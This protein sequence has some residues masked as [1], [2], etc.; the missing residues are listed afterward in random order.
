[1]VGRVP[2]EH[3]GRVI[4]LGAFLLA[5]VEDWIYPDTV[6]TEHGETGR[7]VLR[8]LGFFDVTAVVRAQ[9]IDIINRAAHHGEIG[10]AVDA[11]ARA[12]QTYQRTTR[13][14]GGTGGEADHQ[15][16]TGALIEARACYTRLRIRARAD[17]VLRTAAV[18][19]LP[20][21]TFHLAD[22][23]LLPAPTV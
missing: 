19:A 8:S 22:P 23:A 14:R 5:T 9:L 12:W 11:V 10:A 1:M 13:H 2:A 4:L 20:M 17:A 18:P 15:Q 16:A 6:A 21:P 7:E 3:P